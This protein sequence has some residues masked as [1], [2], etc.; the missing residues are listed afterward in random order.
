MK[1]ISLLGGILLLA[2]SVSF[3][4]CDKSKVVLIRIEN[5]TGHDIKEVFVSGPEDDHD[6]GDLQKGKKSDY[7]TY[8][9]AYRYAFC[10]FKIGDSQYTIQP[11]D[12]VGESLLEPGKYTYRLTISDLDTLWAGMELVD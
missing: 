11:I 6:Y 4:A 8:E 5:S 2:L 10:T 9:K 3:L 7:K 12:F 1:N